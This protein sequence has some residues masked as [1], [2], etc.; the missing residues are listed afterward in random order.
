MSS[1]SSSLPWIFP[2]IISF[3]MA[4]IGTPSL[5]QMGQKESELKAYVDGACGSEA[6]LQIR[7]QNAATKSLKD[8]VLNE[9]QDCTK[10]A[11]D[12]HLQSTKPLPKPVGKNELESYVETKCDSREGVEA[13]IK[14]DEL[15]GEKEQERWD[16]WKKCK[17]DA[18]DNHLKSNQPPKPEDTSC[19]DAR[20]QL[21]KAEGDIKRKCSGD[22]L[23][24]AAKCTRCTLSD[25]EDSDCDEEDLDDDDDVDSEVSELLTKLAQRRQGLFN[26]QKNSNEMEDVRKLTREVKACPLIA[27]DDLKSLKEEVK[28]MRKEKQDLEKDIREKK[29]EINELQTEDA[30][31]DQEFKS[32]EQQLTHELEDM[33]E[34]FKS[35]LKEIADKMREIIRKKKARI[36]EINENIRALK[37]EKINAEDAYNK[38]RWEA[39]GRCHRSA[40]K[41]VGALRERKA[42]LVQASMDRKGGFRS[43]LQGAGLSSRNRSKNLVRRLRRECM[44]DKLFVDE[45]RVLGKNTVKIKEAIQSNIKKG[46]AEKKSLRRQIAN[47]LNVAQAPLKESQK[48]FSDTQRAIDRKQE[49]VNQLRTARAIEH[50]SFQSKVQHTQKEIKNLHLQL[51][52]IEDFLANKQK[53]LGLK[54]KYKVSGLKGDST[55]AIGAVE[56]AK[57]RARDVLSACKCPVSQ[58]PSQEEMSQCGAAYQFLNKVYPDEAYPQF[59]DIGEQQGGGLKEGTTTD[60]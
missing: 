57:S 37:L 33:E 7:L 21:T 45:M 4:F 29:Q 12:T 26:N 43:L 2:W 14:R 16:E 32:N 59:E 44:S 10:K 50:R 34:S 42:K 25:S 23:K 54:Q 41:Q 39:E 55:E 35:Q 15:E 17:G 46:E 9:W 20:S 27:N 49:E 22:C 6:V 30:K 18:A 48:L 53:V 11:A 40:L 56:D 31:A 8:R 36:S 38:A 1:Q 19:K 60:K 5:G 58:T 3:T 47:S 24:K 52:E 51:Q 28:D 13:E